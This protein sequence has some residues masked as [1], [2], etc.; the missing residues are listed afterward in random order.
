MYVLRAYDGLATQLVMQL[1]SCF[2]AGYIY[3]GRWIWLLIWDTVLTMYLHLREA[4]AFVLVKFSA[5]N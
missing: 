2:L 3:V 5:S 1:N 4:V